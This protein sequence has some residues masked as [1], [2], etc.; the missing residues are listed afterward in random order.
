MCRGDKMRALVTGGTGFIGRYLVKELLEK[1]WEVVCTSRRKIAS[2][3]PRLTCVETDIANLKKSDFGKEFQGQFDTIFHLA[4]QL[5]S[6]DREI[7][8][9]LYSKINVQG[10]AALLQIFLQIGARSFI[11][12]SSLSV[13]GKPREL[14]ITEQHP[15]HPECPY[16]ASKLA[17][18][19]LCEDLRRRNKLKIISLR[20]TSPYGPGMPEHSVLPLFVRSALGSRDIN[21]HGSGQRRQNFIHIRD[22]ARACILA[23]TSSSS[24]IF[25]IGGPSSISMFDLASMIIGSIPNCRSRITRGNIPD[26]Q[27][28]YHWDISLELSRKVLQYVPQMKLDTGLPQYIKAISSNT[29]TYKW[30][31]D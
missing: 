6:L 22:A 11:Y 26:P 31:I 9:R 15:T 30:W 8:P 13:I 14:P 2:R 18:E 17:A 3:E 5:P 21:L 12:M 10:T 25:N 19:Q 7:D 16:S 28:A 23:A 29:S 1:G 20:L 4:A 27:E 24:G